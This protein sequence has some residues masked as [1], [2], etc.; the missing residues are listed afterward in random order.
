MPVL[1]THDVL[2][3][4]RAALAGPGATPARRAYAAARV[5]MLDSY[6]AVGHTSA[7]PGDPREL[8]EHIDWD[9][10]LAARR[11]LD[12][13][14]FGVAEAMDTA[15]RFE[16]GWESARR[17]IEQCGRAGFRRPFVAGAGADQVGAVSS[18]A[19]LVDAVVEQLHVIHAA[20]GLPIVLPLPWLAAQRAAPALYVEVYA[21]IV[22][23]APGPLLVHWLGEAFFPALAGYFP[24]DSFL[25]VMALDRDKVRGA[26]ISLL[27]PER[28]VR[29]RRALLPHGQVVFTGDDTRFAALI[30]GSGAPTGALELGGEPLPLGDFSHALMGVFDAVAAPAGLALEALSRGDVA[31]YRALAGPCEA[32]GRH[33]FQAPTGH[34]KAGLA[35]RAWLAGEQENRMLPNHVERARDR[36]HYVEVARLAAEAGALPDPQ[37]AQARLAR[38][39]GA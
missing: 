1:P 15:Q 8:A 7:A 14:G 27:D 3:V 17:L 21:A 12:E 16:I 5:V 2:A 6:A 28:E 32:F 25:E 9:A 39:L 30:E 26:K 10:T 20:G 31:R 34:Y 29:L 35:F 33:V 19:Q 13:L 37:L 36:A 24:G 11:R 22:R 23:A 4:H 38:Y 18:G